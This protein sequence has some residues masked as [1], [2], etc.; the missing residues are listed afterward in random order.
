MSQQK[1]KKVKSLLKTGTS[2][3]SKPPSPAPSASP[4]AAAPAAAPQAPKGSLES[5]PS[6]R[7]KS[8]GTV[9]MNTLAMREEVT[10]AIKSGAPTKKIKH[11]SSGLEFTLIKSDTVGWI[12]VEFPFGKMTEPSRK[13]N[14]NPTKSEDDQVDAASKSTRNYPNEVKKERAVLLSIDEVLAIV[15]T[16][17]PTAAP[18]APAAPSKTA[19]VEAMLEQPA[20]PTPTPATMMSKGTAERQEQLEMSSWSKPPSKKEMDEARKV[21]TMIAKHAEEIG[22][23]RVKKT[24]MEVIQIERKRKA[25]KVSVPPEKKYRPHMIPKGTRLNEMQVLHLAL[26]SKRPKNVLMSGPTG[27]GKTSMVKQYCSDN[28]LPL[29]IVA[30]AEENVFLFGRDRLV[31]SVVKGI[32][33][34]QTRWEDGPVIRAMRNG[35]VLLLDE[36]NALPGDVQIELTTALEEKKHLLPTGEVVVADP[37]F[38]VIGAYNPNYLGTNPLNRAV[39]NR[40][41]YNIQFSYL[42]AERER[43]R[44]KELISGK[45]ERGKYILQPLNKDIPLSDE[46]LEIVEKSIAGLRKIG[47]QDGLAWATSRDV[48]GFAYTLDAWWRTHHDTKGWIPNREEIVRMIAEGM[49]QTDDADDLDIAI[50]EIKTVVKEGAAPFGKE[51]TVSK[52][53]TLFGKLLTKAATAGVKLDVDSTIEGIKEELKKSGE[54]KDYAVGWDIVVRKNYKDWVTSYQKKAAKARKV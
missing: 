53:N 47:E 16:P 48:E 22:D 17:A 18:A 5:K 35:Y 36:I 37:R 15:K 23:E 25:R 46:F 30:C 52:F 1:Q 45:K 50:N 11:K 12:P 13:W 14:F 10:R 49:A 31:K 51:F 33:V 38:R 7:T 42:S 21:Q 2:P 27:S 6:R 44:F 20:P 9:T 41:Q 28:D 34:N 4:A 54:E 3:R 32:P 8:D 24:I 40:F 26:T 29:D 43:E 19:A 39:A